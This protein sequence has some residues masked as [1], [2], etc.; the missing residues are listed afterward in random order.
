MAVI[1]PSS[2]DATH[3]SKTNGTNQSSDLLNTASIA[4][5]TDA[6]LND[7]D[8]STNIN[9]GGGWSVTGEVLFSSYITPNELWL[10]ENNSA[11]GIKVEYTDDG[12]STWSTLFDV[13]GQ[14][15]SGG[16]WNQFQFDAVTMDGIR[17]TVTT[18][19]TDYPATIY[20]IEAHKALIPDD[21]SSTLNA[22]EYYDDGILESTA[23]VVDKSGNAV[24][25]I[26]ADVTITDEN[27]TQIVSQTKTS[28]SN[29]EAT[30]SDILDINADY[31]AD[32]EYEL[33]WN[34]GGYKTFQ[35]FYILPDVQQGNESV[36][37]V[38]SQNGNAVRN[39]E[40]YVDGNFMGYTDTSGELGIRYA[41]FPTKGSGS[42]EFVVIKGNRGATK[43]VANGD[44]EFVKF[45]RANAEE[46]DSLNTSESRYSNVY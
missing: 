33:E 37:Q 38:Y 20:E 5:I 6:V 2:A 16:R 35:P 23:T 22:D 25:N 30:F 13:G 12:G 19:N 42:Y 9:S 3:G 7:D 39:A 26:D 21:I 28:D 1:H 40:V 27:G 36:V 45:G 41:D 43:T 14:G 32:T 29:G 34:A 4:S 8:S 46:T 31:S 17:I 18:N 15:A 10:R 11:D 44:E 24:K